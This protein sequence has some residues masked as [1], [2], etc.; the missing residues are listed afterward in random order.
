M[1]GVIISGIKGGTGKTSIAHALALGAAWNNVNAYVCHTDNRSPMV[2]NGRPY[3]YYDAR[4]P[5]YL[6]SIIK[7]AQNKKG[8]L[9]IDGGGNRTIFDKWVAPC[10]DLMI[11]PITPDPED[12]VLT[13]EYA[14]YLIK[15]GVDNICYLINKY[16]SNSYERKFVQ[17]YIDSIPENMIIGRL[18]E[19]KAIRTLRQSDESKFGTPIARVNNF[20]K[21]VYNIVKEKLDN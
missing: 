8:I 15:S 13:L 1:K 17:G 12:I 3:K 11:I 2:T 21:D 14:S 4:E 20:S 6:K 5:D 10:M 18:K 16:P 9:I 7:S 19:M